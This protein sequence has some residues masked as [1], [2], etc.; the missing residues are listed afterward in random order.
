MA[1]STAQQDAASIAVE[2]ALVD[3]AVYPHQILL[4]Y[5][6]N[7]TQNPEADSAY[8][9]EVHSYTT[10]LASS[11]TNYRYENG[12][13]YHAYKEGSYPYPNDEKE[14]DRLDATH[15]MIE[16]A[17]N[18]RLFGAPVADPRRVLDVGTGTGIWAI[19]FGDRF[20]RA[21]VLGNDLSPIQPRWV[22]PNVRFEVDDVEAEWTFARGFDFIHCRTMSACIRDWPRLVRACRENTVPGGWCEFTDYDIQ[23]T[24]P[25]GSLKPDGLL[26][27]VNRQFFEGLKGQGLEGNPGRYLEEWVREAGF[28]EVHVNKIPLPCGTWPKDKRLVCGWD[29]VVAVRVFAGWC[30]C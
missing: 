28:V 18:N 13:R 7:Q 16:L 19:E 3:Q 21:D 23:W 1:S 10:S 6:S 17:L 4:L 12:R 30:V 20:P 22:P 25:D 9:S 24:S 5:P 27:E 14:S 11:A 8:S 29:F 2:P 15:R 26:L